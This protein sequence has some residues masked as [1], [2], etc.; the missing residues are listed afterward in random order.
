MSTELTAA[1]AAVMAAETARRVGAPETDDPDFWVKVAEDDER[2]VAAYRLLLSAVEP[3][4]AYW[5]AVYD[6]L[7]YRLDKAQRARQMLAADPA[8]KAGAR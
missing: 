1:E 7:Q 2:N 6:A 5:A 8:L 4:T 3:K